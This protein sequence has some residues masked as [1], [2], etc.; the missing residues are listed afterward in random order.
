MFK[1]LVKIQKK[2]ERIW[3]LLVF[4]SFFATPS[5]TQNTDTLSSSKKYDLLNR[6]SV[7]TNLIQSCTG[8]VNMLVN[9]RYW[10]ASELQLGFGYLPFRKYFDAVN[11]INTDY[12]LVDTNFSN[13][14][15][16]NIGLN[17]IIPSQI[18][19]IQ[20]NIN[21]DW[22]KWYFLEGSNHNHSKTRYSFSYGKRILCNSLLSVEGCIGPTLVVHRKNGAE[23]DTYFAVDVGIGINVHLARMKR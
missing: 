2:L 12:P 16:F 20:N 9:Y 4:I 11:Y 8:T 19:F 6:L 23:Q 7:G 10:Y 1:T 14:F 18:K 3:L 22:R 15:Y 21:F 17:L 13:A 5:F